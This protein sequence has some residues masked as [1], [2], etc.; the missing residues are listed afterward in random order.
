[1][2][3]AT[4]AS[5]ELN[6]CGCR[7]CCPWCGSD[8]EE[9]DEPILLPLWREGSWIL[10]GKRKGWC[11]PAL[12]TGSIW[13][14]AGKFCPG[15]AALCDPGEDLLW[16]PIQLGLA[17]Q[18]TSDC[19]ENTITCRI[20]NSSLTLGVYFCSAGRCTSPWGELALAFWWV[21]CTED[22]SLRATVSNAHYC[23]A[24]PSASKTW[25]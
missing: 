5:K 22:I 11:H 10:L 23:C 3:H 17:R 25:C 20:L 13:M 4:P 1:M 12:F 16:C 14:S 7:N 6:S 24:V 15:G 8:A 9:A 2:Q 18:D 19:F 21:I